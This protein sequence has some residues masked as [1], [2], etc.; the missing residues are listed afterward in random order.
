MI[1][2]Q[3]MVKVLSE[4]QLFDPPETKPRDMNI[5]LELDL[6]ISIVGPRRAGIFIS[7]GLVSGGSDSCHSDN[8][9]IRFCLSI[10]SYDSICVYKLS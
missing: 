8:T 5:P 6:I 4:W 2:R 7:L 9:F 1:E 3:N 10:I